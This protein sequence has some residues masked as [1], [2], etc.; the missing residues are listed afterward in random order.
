MRVIVILKSLGDFVL[1]HTTCAVS[2]CIIYDCFIY[3][4]N[5]SHMCLQHVNDVSFSLK[6]VSTTSVSQHSWNFPHVMYVP[7]FR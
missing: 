6:A 3:K 5:C 4:S 2:N 7:V 1:V